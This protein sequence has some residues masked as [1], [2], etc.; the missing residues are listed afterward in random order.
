MGLVVGEV[1]RLAVYKCRAAEKL[2]HVSAPSISDERQPCF[3]MALNDSDLYALIKGCHR[4]R[5][6]Y[7]SVIRPA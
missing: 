3:V 2:F 7:T 6:R 4:R 5:V 1:Q